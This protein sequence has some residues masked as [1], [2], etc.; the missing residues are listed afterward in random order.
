M[1][2]A[3]KR[4]KLDVSDNAKRYLAKQGFQPE[5]GARPLKRFVYR[6]IAFSSLFCRVIQREV[7]NPLAKL[8]LAGSAGKGDTVKISLSPDNTL[9]FDVEVGE[10]IKPE[11][12]LLAQQQ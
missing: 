2:Y 3:E 11:R 10:T 1:T 6:S 12:E 9:Q 5:Y 8:L 7:L 4:V